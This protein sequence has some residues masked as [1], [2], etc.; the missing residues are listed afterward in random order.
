MVGGGGR[1]ID[2][3]GG[4]RTCTYVHVHMYYVAYE[5]KK[6]RFR[7]GLEPQKLYYALQCKSS[8]LLIAP[9]GLRQL[10]TL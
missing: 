10:E 4:N 7:S 9:S 1:E 3:L 5:S 2:F 8:A 6:K